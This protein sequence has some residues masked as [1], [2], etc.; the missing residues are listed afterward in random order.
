[1]RRFTPRRPW[2][3]LAD[4]EWDALA[5]FLTR[6]EGTPGRPLATPLRTR[7]DAMLRI[8]CT[9]A[10][11]HALPPGYGKG[12]TVARHFRRLAHAGLCARLLEA[13]AD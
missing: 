11:W 4:A 8:A 7:L 12:E 13:L 6:A 2:V 1:M 10:P 3:P 9:D 5:P